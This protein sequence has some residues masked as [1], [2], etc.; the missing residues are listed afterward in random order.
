MKIDSSIQKFILNWG[1]IASNWGMNRTV[2][3]IHA[4][5]LISPEPLTADEIK[6]TLQVARSNVSVSLRELQN[7]GLVEMHSVME[8]RKK[9]F[10]AHKDIQFIFKQIM[11]ERKRREVDMAFKCLNECSALIQQAG[12]AHQISELKQVF[13]KLES[14][15]EGLIN[16][17]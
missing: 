15:Y 6:A 16:G 7:W 13:H 17:A 8:D 3:H 2:A 14:F 11:R 5:L 1:Q 9:R 12:P 10:A 4:L